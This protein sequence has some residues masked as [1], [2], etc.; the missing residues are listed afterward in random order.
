MGKKERELR[1]REKKS[2]LLFFSLALLLMI[3]NFDTRYFLGGDNIRYLIL[4]QSLITGQGYRDI[5]FPSSPPHTTYP[6]G[7]PLLLGPFLL[8]FG[9]NYPLLNTLPL[10]FAIFALLIFHQILK[11][12]KNSELATIYPLILLTSSPIFLQYSHT[13]LSEMPFIFFSLLAFYLFQR[14]EKKSSFSFLLF[15][16]LALTF[17]LFI[18]TAG[19]GIFP[20][21]F[22]YLLL[23]K[24]YK[25]LFLILFI[26][27]LFFLPYLFRNSRVG[28]PGYLE[29]FT[30]K[31]PY[32]PEEGRISLSDYLGRVGE[33]F[34]LYTFFVF[35][36]MLFPYNL[37]SP[38]F[39]LIGLTSLIFF[40]F[41]FYH[42]LK[43]GDL[44]FLLYLL[45]SLFILYSWPPVW[46]GDR[47]LLPLFPFLLYYLF[48]G[49]KILFKRSPS[50]I[51]LLFGLILLGY[52]VKDINT[53]Q[54]NL[55]V[56]L[57]HL[58]GDK[59]AGY[60]LDWI[61]YFQAC[62]WLKENTE[63]EAIIASRKPEF[64][65]FLTKR[66]SF[67]YKFSNEPKDILLD[68]KE[69]GATHLLFDQFF[70]TNT[71]LRYL[72][73]LLR[74]FSNNFEPLHSTDYPQMVLYKT[75][76]PE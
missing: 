63:E 60:P 12:S 68:L 28:G 17:S 14:Y 72:S 33:N 74:E 67:L 45:F 25:E 57:A 71:S 44:L 42:S 51:T 53:I 10:F 2:F 66:K 16:F 30:Y 69:K 73:P 37:P 1:K 9:E 32:H 21:F 46:T 64:V 29:L 24:R 23:K 56:N 58:R 8:L 6:P 50:L 18:R 34:Y 3:L 4:A 43:R 52:L 75:R 36:Q 48:L 59:Y 22:F 55:S 70:W 27:L 38:L 62:E 19:I 7:F 49:L 31:N 40:F 41:G 54:E 15:S 39:F 13:L 5:H 20:A 76:Y 26:F 65:Y 61:R 35:P 47:F 11:N